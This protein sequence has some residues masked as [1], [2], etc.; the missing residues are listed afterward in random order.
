MG[1]ADSLEPL[2][3]S[4]FFSNAE[5]KKAGFAN[6]LPGAPASMEPLFF[7]AENAYSLCSLDR[8]RDASMEPL[9]FK[10]ENIPSRFGSYQLHF[11]LQWSRLLSNAENGLRIMDNRYQ[12]G[13]ASMEPLYFKAENSLR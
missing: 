13:L 9:F 7:K 2:Q 12:Y 5:N 3:W 1:S 8:L 11:L 4:R 10:A 6:Y